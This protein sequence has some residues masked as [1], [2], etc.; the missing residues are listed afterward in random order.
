MKKVPQLLLL[1][2]PIINLVL[3][4]CKLSHYKNMKS[5]YYKL[6]LNLTYQGNHSSEIYNLLQNFENVYM[7]Q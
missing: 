6:S 7:L 3:F 2:T 4:I 1:I 5:L